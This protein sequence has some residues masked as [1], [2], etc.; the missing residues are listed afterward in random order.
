MNENMNESFMLEILKGAISFGSSTVSGIVQALLT[1][2]FLR[3]NTSTNEFEKIKTNRFSE[4]IDSLLN[5]GKMTYLEYYKCTNFLEIARIADEKI[6]K[7]DN[8]SNTNKYDFDWFVQFY[9]YASNTSNK[10]IQQLWASILAREISNPSSVSLSLLHALSIMRKEQALFFCN[11]SRFVFSDI[12][13]QTSLPL[14]FIS[15]NREAYKDSSIT[16]S[17]LKEMEHLGLIECDFS[18]EYICNRKK[19][20]RKGNNN[21]TVYGD[22]DNNNKIKCG[23]IKFTQDGEMLYSIIDDS[24]KTYRHDIFD[25]TISKFKARN[26]KVLVNDKEVL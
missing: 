19:I 25:F 22:P 14:I 12:T 5:S 15:T 18:N 13:Y 11:I 23:N 9:E 2:L 8:Q 24:F 4:V 7:E 3:K 6:N 17:R 20:F 10:E 16:P 1:T 26:C 21:I